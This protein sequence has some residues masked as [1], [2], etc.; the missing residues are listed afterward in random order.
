MLDRIPAT[1]ARTHSAGASVA[2]V[3]GEAASAATGAIR[4]WAEKLVSNVEDG[5]K[6]YATT[7]GG[8]A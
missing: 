4:F 8:I 6:G 7:C 3:G 5:K 1:V 2:A